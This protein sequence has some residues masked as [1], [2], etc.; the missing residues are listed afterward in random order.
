MF[1]WLQDLVTASPITYVVVGVT[2]LVE[3][4]FP[5]LPSETLLVIGGIFAARGDLSVVALVAVGWIAATAGDNLTYTVGAHPGKKLKK[6]LLRGDRGQRAVEWASDRLDDRPW[7][8][9]FVRFVPALREATTF[10]A[11]SVNMPRGRF[12][13]YVTLGAFLWSAL[14]V[15]LGYLGG[16][17]FENSFFL[18]LLISFA[19]A[20]LIALAGE[21]V[22]RRHAAS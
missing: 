7:I 17:A 6:R 21:L 15:L 10:T 8:L 4:I 11:G 18:S 20:G 9:T 12:T 1:D 5:I 19:A 13:A 3:A 14:H 22:H 16:R 2:I